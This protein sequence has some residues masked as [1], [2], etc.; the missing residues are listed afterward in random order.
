[1]SKP[2]VDL[3]R[4]GEAV[5]WN[6][7]IGR[8]GEAAQKC[9]DAE[10]RER[11]RLVVTLRDNRRLRVHK[12]EVH[13]HDPGEESPA[14]FITGYVFIGQYTGDEDSHMVSIS[15][16]PAMISSVEWVVLPKEEDVPFGFAPRDGER[17]T[18][19]EMRD[20]EEVH[21]AVSLIQSDELK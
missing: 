9:L 6:T 5:T 12:T 15:V 13:T 1:M 7:W 2:L 11:L 3:G 8:A 17:D 21:G 18:V 14:T 19:T 16:V 20:G 4:E 10:D